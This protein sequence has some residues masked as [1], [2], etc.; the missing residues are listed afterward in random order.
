MKIFLSAVTGE[1][2]RYREELH[3]ALLR[4]KLQPR[5]Q[6]NFRPGTATLLE[7]LR[8]E[9]RECDRVI[10]LIGERCG[11]FPTDNELKA[12]GS[13]DEFNR[14]CAATGQS[15]A[16]YSQWEFF[17]ARHL[18]K[19]IQVFFTGKD[20]VPKEKNSEATDLQ[21]C[22][23]TYRDWIVRLG[24]ARSTISTSEK[25]IEDVLVDDL[26]TRSGP[27]PN[28]LPY[29][30]LGTLF[31]G[32][33]QFIAQLKQSLARTMFQDTNRLWC[34]NRPLFSSA[35]RCFHRDTLKFCS[36]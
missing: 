34:R 22:Q 19:P 10:L 25:L 31:K 8:D 36:R 3:R 16:S 12:I 21:A 5:T 11:S 13:I 17:L 23:K 1:L 9:I 27:R 24:L 32:R 20:F 7:F 4:K 6:E 18:D 14:Y 26:V 29:P 35:F 28:N 2:G 33:D 30:S 15:R